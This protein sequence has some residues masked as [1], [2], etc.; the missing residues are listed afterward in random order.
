MAIL[1]DITDWHCR[2]VHK[3][4]KTYL[5]TNYFFKDFSRTFFQKIS[6]PGRFSSTFQ[7]FPG[8]SRTSGHPDKNKCI[9]KMWGKYLKKKVRKRPVSLLK[10]SRWGSSVS[11]CTNQPPVFSISGTSI[12]NELFQTITALKRLMSYSKRLH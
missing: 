11:A 8:F 5:L 6:F 7:D 1:W 10:I 3:I 9:A 12:P 2:I 4:W